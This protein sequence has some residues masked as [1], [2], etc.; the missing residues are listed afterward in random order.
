[1][2]HGTVDQHARS[3]SFFHVDPRAKVVGFVFTVVVV[4]LLRD[5]APLLI[6]LVFVIFL[7]L[8]SNIPPGHIFKRYTMALPFIL[9]ASASLY[10]YSGT[11]TSLAMF[12]RVSSCVLL[13]VLLSSSTPFFDL[14]RASQRLGMPRLIIILMMFMY[15]YIFVFTE[16]YQRMRM[17]RSARG[18]SGGK[19]LLDKRAMMALSS[20]AGMLLVRAYQRGTRIYDALLCRGYDGK[21]RTLTNM[22]LA[23]M[24]IAFSCDVML[25]SLFILWIDWLVIV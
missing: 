15:R 13:L 22:H 1:M 17:A 8:L 23:P 18:F 2:K 6:V 25:F 11:I 14:L 10:L 3:S 20:T 12:L 16:E 7:I 4:A 19:H 24:D 21:I 5:L 9:I